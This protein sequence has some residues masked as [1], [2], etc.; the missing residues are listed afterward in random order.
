MIDLHFICRHGENLTHLEGHRYRS[1][2]WV[3]GTKTADEA[4]GGNIR[5]HEAQDAPAYHGGQILAWCDAPEPENA[6][7][8]YFV[9]EAEAGYRERCN[10]NWGRE[11]CI[12]RR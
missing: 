1:G 3:V 7:R 12:V 9:Y 6:G 10:G 5:L 4:V 2:A 8:K 11:K